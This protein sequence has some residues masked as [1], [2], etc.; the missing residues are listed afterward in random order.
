M[1]KI[2]LVIM[3]IQ[4]LTLHA[5]IPASAQE[6][7]PDEMDRLARH[8]FPEPIILIDAGHGGIDG[9]TSFKEIL[10]KD[11]NLDISRKLYLILKAKGYRAVLNRSED[12][13]LS[14]DNHWLKSRSRHMRDLAQRKA[15]S[16]ELTTSIVVSVHVNWGRNN[17]KRGPVVLHQNEGRSALLASAIQNALDP[18]YNTRTWPMLGKPFYLLNHVAYPAVIVET[19]YLSNAQ[20]RAMLTRSKGQMEI[21]KAIAAGIMDYF[22]EI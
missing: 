2:L 6:A 1:K 3:A 16:D 12:Y 20:D 22:T 15:L 10:E 19:G 9:G 8:A 14:D 17:A 21:A 13:A 11:I 4:F 18:L 5:A 7:R